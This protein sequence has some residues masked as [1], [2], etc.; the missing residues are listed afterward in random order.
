VC[1]GRRSSDRFGRSA[2]GGDSV[3]AARGGAAGGAGPVGRRGSGSIAPPDAQG[4]REVEL[5]GGSNSE[6]H[7]STRAEMAMRV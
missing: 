6:P 5:G 3:Y 1:L 4:F 7:A 2:F